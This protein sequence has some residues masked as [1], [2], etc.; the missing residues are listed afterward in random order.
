MDSPRRIMSRAINA[1]S[2]ALPPPLRPW[3]RSVPRRTIEHS[4]R[5]R[6]RPW[7]ARSFQAANVLAA[8]PRVTAPVNGCDSR[9]ST[10]A[11]RDQDQ[12]IKFPTRDVAAVART[13]SSGSP[14]PG[15]LGS[16]RGFLDTLPG[17]SSQ[18]ATD[19][20]GPAPYG[21]AADLPS[22]RELSQQ[23]VG[24]KLLT[25]FFFRQH[26][27]EL[28]E[29]EQHLEHLTRVVDAFYDR[30]GA[31]FTKTI[32]RRVD[33]EVFDVYRH[34]IMHGTVVNFNNPIVATKAW[35]MVFAVSDWA[36]ATEKAKQPKE[37][38]PTLSDTWS[39]LSRHASYRKHQRE[40]VPVTVQAADAVF[41]TDEVAKSASDFLEAWEHRR[42][43]HVAR[44]QAPML[45]GPKSGGRA[46]SKTK[47]RFQ[48]CRLEGWAITSVVHDHPSAAEISAEATVNDH[49]NKLQFRMG[50]L[51]ADGNM[52]IRG[53]KDAR[54]YVIDWFPSTSSRP[55]SRIALGP[56]R[57]TVP[58]RFCKQPRPQG[59]PAAPP[60]WLPT[61]AAA[62]SEA[63][64]HFLR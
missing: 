3:V 31:T 10:L 64:V 51:T 55:P 50:L 40:F 33:D 27:S 56:N 41:E 13:H 61:D 35:N 25:R 32:K 44:F 23:I 59:G 46:A 39:E 11:G 21:S 36:T 57:G 37:P 48:R 26:H 14:R 12:N 54:W 4:D 60:G 6:P 5:E 9:T 52:A 58:T 2:G 24:G 45:R 62:A 49:G 22:F 15:L 53:D 17:V 38:N 20:N 43:G 19:S 7:P 28:V 1:R 8:T 42:W 16:V 63:T 30:L 47:E 18:P 34:G 29:I